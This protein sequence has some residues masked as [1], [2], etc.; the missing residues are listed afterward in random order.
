MHPLRLML[1]GLTL[2]LGLSWNVSHAA[3]CGGEVACE[4]AGGTYYVA[5]PKD[6]AKGTLFFLHGWGG[7]GK[8][9]MKNKG[10]IKAFNKAGY[11]LIA[12]TGQP[13]GQGRSGY[14]WNAFAFEQFRDDVAFLRAVADDAAARFGLPRERMGL[15]GFSGGGMMAWRVACDAPESFA[16]YLPVAGLLW[17]PLPE[18]CKGPVKMLHTHGWSD[19]V[20]PIE[21]RSVAGGR[22]TQGDLGVGLDLIR[23][24][25][26]CIKDDPDK[27]D[28]SGAMWHRTWTKCQ[29]GSALEYVLHP[30]G[31]KVP[32]GW[33]A[34]ALEW[35]ARVGITP[36]L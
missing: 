31:H 24:A 5:M 32:R 13:R 34:V 28:V 26:K 17:R 2:S 29:E 35:L 8:G 14:R 15:G 23:R 18:D 20:V 7:S 30:A 33:Y 36:A 16:A 9:Q 4:V 25:N 3:G 22:Y 10:M 27:Y 21:G 6:E 12:P 19:P 1:A 11:A